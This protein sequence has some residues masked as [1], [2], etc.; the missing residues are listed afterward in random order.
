MQYAHIANLTKRYLATVQ[1]CIFWLFTSHVSL[2]TA[3][4]SAKRPHE[5]H[6]LLRS[7]VSE[8]ERLNFRE[9]ATFLFCESERASFEVGSDDSWS[10]LA[11]VAQCIDFPK[12]T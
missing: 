3:F 11:A 7:I 1:S 5:G 8:K 6:R 2:V 12:T 9:L 4:A 10:A